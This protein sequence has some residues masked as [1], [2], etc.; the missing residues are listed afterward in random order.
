VAADVS[1]AEVG[2]GRELAPWIDTS[3]HRNW[4]TGETGR[5]LDFYLGT[6]DFDGGGFWALDR[7]GAPVPGQPKE[8]WI[9]ARLVHCFALGSLLGHPGCAALTEHGLDALRRVFHDPE[10]GGWYW[11]ATARKQTYGHAFVLLAASTATQAGFAAADLV[12]EATHLIETRLFEPDQGLYVEGWDRGWNTCEDYRGQ[13]PNMHLVEAFM[14]AAEATGD[15]GFI[16]RAVPVAARV[17]GEFAAADGWRIPEHYTAGWQPQPEFNRDKPRDVLRPYGYTPG[18]SLEWARLL[19]QL[20]AAAGDGHDWMLDTAQ[21]LFRR[22]VADGWDSERTGFVYTVGGDG[23]VGVADRF[24]WG[25]TEAIGAAAYLYRAT[26]D[27]AYD[28]WYRQFWDHA[29]LFLI[30]RRNGSWWHELTPANQP[31]DT[32]WPGKP[33]LYHALQATLFART[34]LTA[35]LGAALAAGQVNPEAGR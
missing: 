2:S 15:H 26:A 23:Q 9:N 24:H 27:P 13:N 12:A 16:D 8:L 19:I 5:L 34:P 7:T 14:A 11:S 35:G 17:I 3:G 4:L 29:A 20:R 21:H 33:D 18:H 32:T 31:G 22:A 6:A 28:R 10:Y 1:P 30:D 25:A